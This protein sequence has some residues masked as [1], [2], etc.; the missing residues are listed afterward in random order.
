MTILYIL[1]DV[2]GVYAI[3]SFMLFLFFGIIFLV[4]HDQMKRRTK[5]FLIISLIVVFVMLVLSITTTAVLH[6]YNEAEYGRVS[7]KSCK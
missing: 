7:E 2:S 4:G 5:R 3:A 1:E 6:A